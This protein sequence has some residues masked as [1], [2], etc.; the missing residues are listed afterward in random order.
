VEVRSAH[1][2]FRPGRL[3]GFFDG[4]LLSLGAAEFG[5]R[6]EIRPVEGLQTA[7]DALQS[8]IFHEGFATAAG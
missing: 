1:R 2:N 5:E 3:T 4:P 7:M 8:S 6:P